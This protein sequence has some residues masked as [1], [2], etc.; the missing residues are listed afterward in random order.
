MI[1]EKATINQDRGKKMKNSKVKTKIHR[2]RKIL[3]DKKQHLKELEYDYENCRSKSLKAEALSLITGEKI[4]IIFL[5]K[6][7]RNGEKG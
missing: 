1:T 4:N 6:Q 2:L 7:I 5:K 3:S